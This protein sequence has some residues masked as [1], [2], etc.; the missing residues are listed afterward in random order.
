MNSV[1]DANVLAVANN[2][3]E[4]AAPA[5]WQSCIRFLVS[6][7]SVG[8][9]VSVDDL[10]EI[11][12]EYSRYASHAGQPGLGDAFFKWL[13][14]NQGYDTVCEKVPITPNADRKYE[15]FPSDPLLSAFDLSDRKYVAVSL[16]SRRNPIIYNAVDS[17]WKIF[18]HVFV[19]LDIPVCQLCL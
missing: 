15:E 12:K 13:F 7:Q 2:L 9:C 8:G 19:Q 5:C 3:H 16:T 4:Q 10:G 1:I 11:F 14:Q 6:V 17:D 18:E